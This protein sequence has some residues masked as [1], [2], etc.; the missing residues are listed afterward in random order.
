QALSVDAEVIEVPTLPTASIRHRAARVVET[1]AQVAQGSSAPTHLVGHSTGGL[2]ARLAV[3]PTASVPTTVEFADYARL[4]TLVAVSA[5]RF[6]TP[7][8]AAFGSAAGIQLLRLAAMLTQ[9]AITR[10][11]LPLGM[12]LRLGGLITRI[13]DRLGFPDTVADSFFR[14]ITADFSP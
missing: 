9:A 14:D 12:M 7:L 1:L 4:R 11:H 2:D 6:G 8:A 5:A 13:A 3:A 10:A